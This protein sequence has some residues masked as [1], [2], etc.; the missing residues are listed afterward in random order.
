MTRLPPGRRRLSLQAG[1][2]DAQGPEPGPR[3]NV[4]VPISFGLPLIV[5]GLALLVAA[6]SH[7]RRDLL[8]L[9][10]VLGA[11][12]VA[13]VA[14]EQAELAPLLLSPSL[15]LALSCRAS[16]SWRRPPCA[17]C[18]SCPLLALHSAGGLGPAGADSRGLSRDVVAPVVPGERSREH[19]GRRQA[20]VSRW[21]QQAWGW[22][23]EGELEVRDGD[24]GRPS[25]LTALSIPSDP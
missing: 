3:L 24:V 10:G 15:L 6:I 22:P 18:A 19:R 25:N 11:L 5:V 21:R 8:D 7:R 14:S 13:L 16:S 2:G 4:S 9:R 1:A 20:Q 23:V 17:S 12:G